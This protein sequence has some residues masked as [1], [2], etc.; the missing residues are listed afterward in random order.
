MDGR[1]DP[2]RLIRRLS[3]Q[4]GWRSTE[5]ALRLFHTGWVGLDTLARSARFVF[6]DVPAGDKRP[7]T[8]ALRKKVSDG[9][10]QLIWDFF[11]TGQVVIYD[12][13]N[14][15][16]AARQTLA[17]KFHAKGIHVVML[18]VFRWSRNN[19]E[20][21]LIIGRIHVRRQGNHREKHPERQDLFA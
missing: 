17:D 21:A 13:N 18:G 6:T 3:P 1:Q 5:T 4:G 9:C 10:E 8:I 20:L 16:R 12:A 14:G 7:E 15:T 11:E 19:L 2:G